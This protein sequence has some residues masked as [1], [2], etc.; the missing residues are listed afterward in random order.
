MWLIKLTEEIKI[1]NEKLFYNVVIGSFVPYGQIPNTFNGIEN[2]IGGYAER[3]DLHQQD[4]FFEFMTPEYSVYQKQGGVIFDEIKKVYTYEVLEK[5]QEEIEYYNKSLIPQVV[6]QRQLRTQLSLNGF[7]LG[8]VQAVI[9]SLPDPNKTIAQI[10]WDYSLTFVRNDA[11]LNSI[12]G[13]LGIS[14][15]DLDQ[16][17]INASKL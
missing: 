2:I 16:I 9:D 17:F 15:S 11:L 5:T 12:S 4:G 7:D 3:T 8:D 1:K 6:S 14:Q 13:I 10:A